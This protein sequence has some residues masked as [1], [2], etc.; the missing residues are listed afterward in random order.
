LPRDGERRTQQPLQRGGGEEIVL[1][2]EDDPCRLR[3]AQATQLSRQ[4]VTGAL[5]AILA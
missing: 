4:G 1:W 2:T 3:Q 5:E